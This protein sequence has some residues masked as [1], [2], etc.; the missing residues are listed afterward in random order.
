M[1]EDDCF[2]VTLNWSIDP[3]HIQRRNQVSLGPWPVVP[4]SFNWKSTLIE[5]QVKFLVWTALVCQ[6]VCINM[7]HGSPWVSAY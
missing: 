2:F 4:G 5:N 7:L 6:W 1:S 3:S